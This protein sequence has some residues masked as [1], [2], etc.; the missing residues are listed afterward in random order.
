MYSFDIQYRNAAGTIIDLCLSLMAPTAENAERK[1]T[2]VWVS[3][4]PNTEII[5]IKAR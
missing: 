3:I 5:N 4:C 2:S 1:I